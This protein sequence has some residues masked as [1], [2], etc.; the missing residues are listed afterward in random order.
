VKD[1]KRVLDAAIEAF[2]RYKSKVGPEMQRKLERTEKMRKA[3]MAESERIRS[4]RKP[5]S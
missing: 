5:T 4:E 2:K 1:Q 3:A